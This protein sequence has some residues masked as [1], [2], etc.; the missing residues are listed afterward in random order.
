MPLLPFIWGGLGLLAGGGGVWFLSGKVGTML[1]WGALLGGGYLAY[2]HR[3]K[4][5]GIFK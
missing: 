4:I 3:A 1:K 2:K 5:K